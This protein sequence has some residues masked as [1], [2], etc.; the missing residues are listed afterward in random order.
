VRGDAAQ[1]VGWQKASGLG[2]PALAV[3]ALQMVGMGAAAAER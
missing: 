2:V 1:K 3:L